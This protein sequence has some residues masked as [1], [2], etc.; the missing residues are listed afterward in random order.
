M[1]SC[2]LASATRKAEESMRREPM[3]RI[4]R[5]GNRLSKRG[6]RTGSTSWRQWREDVD[7]S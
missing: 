4:C 6:S 1:S 3:K 7:P 2:Y 5:G